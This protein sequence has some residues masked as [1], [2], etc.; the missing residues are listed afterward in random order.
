MEFEPESEKHVSP[1]SSQDLDNSQN[2]N[3][4]EEEL[5]LLAAK[6]ERLKMEQAANILENRVLYLEKINGKMNKKIES[7]KTRAIEIMKLKKQNLEQ[8]E[9]KR[10][11]GELKEATLKEKQQKIHE[12]RSDH[13]QKLNTSKLNS[14]SNSMMIAKNTKEGLQVLLKESKGKIQTTK[15]RNSQEQ[16][17]KRASYSRNPQ[18]RNKQKKGTNS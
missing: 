17:S 2:P 14:I 10:N 3:L 11:F 8:D 18:K 12:M 15:R 16:L 6:K 13:E 7:A 1:Q 5:R 4:N 9:A